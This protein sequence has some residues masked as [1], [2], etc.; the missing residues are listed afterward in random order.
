MDDMTEQNA[1]LFARLGP[2][3]VADPYP[4][5]ESLRSA[6]PVVWV[7]GVFG[8]GAWV[9]T[10]H[11]ACAAALKSKQLGKEG[12]RVL[13]PEKLALLPQEGL[14]VAERRKNNMLFRDP[15]D[16]TRLRGLVNQAFTP[17][18]VE[19]LRPHVAG[20]AEHLL[21]AV[22]ASGGGD[23]IRA[24]AFPLPIIVIA[25]LLGVPSGDRDRFKDWSTVLTL[26]I[27]PGV[28]VD[29][30]RRVG[31]VMEELSDYLREVIEARRREPRADLISEL[32]RVQDAGDRLSLDEL[33]GTCRVLLTAGHETTV[34][35]IGNGTLALLQNPAQRAAVEAD[36]ALLPGAIEELLR[37]DSPVQ[38]TIRFAMEDTPLGPHQARRGDLAILLLGAANRD[39]GVFEAPAAV[40]VRRANA[41]AHLSFGSG[42]HYCVGASLARLEGEI[43]VG[44]LLRRFPKL[45][46]AEGPLEWRP[47]TVLRGLKAMPV[48]I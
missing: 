43:A 34:N 13:P 37:Y 25:E 24:F 15:P 18:T 46:L 11:A 21:D 38:M 42:I 9:V 44:A 26:G 28:S 30:L 33:L 29:D 27:Q 6:G 16:H 47:H 23:L 3:F 48:V 22:A 39:P 45:A 31:V 41:Q 19:R 12:Y 40:D 20:I 4:F 1:D 7:P 32:V 10:G 14:E 36:A 8:L 35:L 5:Y 2:G 17:R